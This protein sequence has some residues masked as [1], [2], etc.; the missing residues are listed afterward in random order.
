MAGASTGRSTRE[1]ALAERASG[2]QPW[3]RESAARWTSCEMLQV[4]GIDLVILL[5]NR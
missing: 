3:P 2:T 4:F 1:T 5:V